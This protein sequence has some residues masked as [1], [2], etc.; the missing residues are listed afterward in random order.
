MALEL[1][2]VS[3]T[4]SFGY[5]I[6]EIILNVRDYGASTIG[7]VVERRVVELFDACFE[8]VKK[9]ILEAFEQKQE[10]YV[11]KRLNDFARDIAIDSAK[12]VVQHTS[13]AQRLLAEIDMLHVRMDAVEAKI[14][15]GVLSNKDLIDIISNHV[16][17]SCDLDNIKGYLEGLKQGLAASE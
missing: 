14:S 12:R 3:S 8:K 11:G 6:K 17:D 10:L 2:D 7:S 15:S 4:D 9:I 5:G 1:K 13:E 16:G